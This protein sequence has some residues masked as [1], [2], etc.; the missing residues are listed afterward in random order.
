M[1]FEMPTTSGY[2]DA[3]FSWR[4]AGTTLSTAGTLHSGVTS[5]TTAS[6][7]TSNFQGHWLVVTIRIPSTYTAPQNGWWK[8][9]YVITGG[10]AH[11]RTTWSAQIIDIPV[12][13]VPGAN[14]T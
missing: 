5:V 14:P 9:K 6:G 11:D 4:D 12:H 1:Y 7:G 8:I 10:A 3:T 2:T 13:L